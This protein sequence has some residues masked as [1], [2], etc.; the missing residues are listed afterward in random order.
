M[1]LS[2]YK[3]YNNYDLWYTHKTIQS[4]FFPQIYTPSDQIYTLEGI[5]QRS[6]LRCQTLQQAL[7]GTYKWLVN[8]PL[9]GNN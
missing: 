3:H 8:A 5:T 1:S 9:P 7:T 6:K 2:S 4:T